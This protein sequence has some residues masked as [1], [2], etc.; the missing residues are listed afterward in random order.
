MSPRM[1]RLLVLLPVLCFACSESSEPGVSPSLD[2]VTPTDGDPVGHGDVSV[3][4]SDVQ[5]EP[6]ADPS[7][8]PPWFGEKCSSNDDCQAEGWADGYCVQ[9]DETGLSQCTQACVS[10]CPPGYGCVAIQ[11]LGGSDALFVCMPIVPTGCDP[12][13]SDLDCPRPGARCLGIGLDGGVDDLRC[14]DPCTEGQAACLAGYVCTSTVVGDQREPAELC[15]PDTG[16]CICF[17]AD[18]S[19]SP[20]NG[21]SRPC[22]S[23]N[24]IGTCTGTELCDGTNGWTG[25]T[26]TQPSAEVCNGTD[27]DCNGLADDGMDPVPCVHQNE[28]GACV[29][30]ETCAGLDGWSCDA[31]HPAAETCDG[32]DEDCNGVV[33]DGFPDMD[34][35]GIAD[36]IDDDVDGDG[37]TDT[38][39]NCPQVSN[40][41]QTDTDSDLLGDACDT[42]DDGDGIPDGTD[43]CPQLANAGQGDLDADAQGDA[44]DAD[45]DGDGVDNDTDVCPTTADPGQEDSDGDGTGDACDDD[46]DGDGVSDAT[47]CAPNDPA[48][49]PGQVEV[50]NGADDDC[51]FITDEGFTDTDADGLADCTDDDD[52][53]DGAVDDDD[54]LPLVATAYPGADEVCNGTDDDCDGDTDEGFPDEDTDGVPDCLDEDLDGDG[55][56]NGADVCPAVADPAQEDLDGDG[57]GDAC[58]ADD[59]GDAIPDGTDNCPAV[60]NTVQTDTDA[61][62]QGDACDDDDDG[63]GVADGADNCALVANAGQADLDSDGVG[64]ACEDDIDG[65][66]APD[67]LDCAPE[68]PAV[69]PGAVEACDGVDNDCSGGVDEGFVDTD[70]DGEKDC[71]DSDDDGDLDPDETDCAPLNA[72]IHHQASEVCNGVDD[73]CDG[74]VDEDLGVLTCGKGNCAHTVPACQDGA[75]QLCDPF[76][77]IDFEVCDGAGNDCDGL[78][79]EDQ[80]WLSCGLGACVHAVYQC[81]DA[82]PVQCDPLEGSS[83]ELCNGLDDDCDGVIDDELGIISCGVGACAKSVPACSDG[84]ANACDADSGKSDEVCDGVD[85]DCDGAVDEGAAACTLFYA[86]ADGDG[87]GGGAGACLCEAQAPYTYSESTDCNDGDAAVKPGILEI[88][89]N[90]K[91]DNCDGLIDAAQTPW[92]DP[93]GPT[94]THQVIVDNSAGP[95]LADY[96]V[97]VDVSALK[98]PNKDL[99]VALHFDEATGAYA[100]GA[101]TEERT[102]PGTFSGA[103]AFTA[104]GLEGAGLTLPGSNSSLQYPLPD[105]DPSG[106][107]TYTTWVYAT[108]YE[109]NHAS[110]AY[111]TDNWMRLFYVTPSAGGAWHSGLE[112][113]TAAGCHGHLQ[114]PGLGASAWKH[115]VLQYEGAATNKAHWYVDGKKILSFSSISF[116][117]L[118][119]AKLSLGGDQNNGASY[120]L[121]GRIDEVLWYKKALSDTEIAAIYCHG[122]AKLGQS[123]AAC[124]GVTDKGRFDHRDIRVLSSDGAGVLPSWIG[125]DR[126]LW[127]KIGAQAAGTTAT[128]PIQYGSAAVQGDDDPAAVFSLYDGFEGSDGALSSD[129]KWTVNGTASRKAH[130]AC[131]DAGAA[132]AADSS[133]GWLATTATFDGA[134]TLEASVRSLSG[135]SSHFYSVLAMPGAPTFY[136]AGSHLRVRDGAGGESGLKVVVDSVVA[137]DGAAAGAGHRIA[138][139]RPVGDEHVTRFDGAVLSSGAW[140]GAGP[141]RL[142]VGAGPGPAGSGTY[143][144]C[145]DR[146]IVRPVVS[147]EP[148]AA[149]AP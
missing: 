73:N 42:D 9:V 81:K 138:L 89:D 112:F 144:A 28:H 109:S 130:R 93:G 105:L 63:D 35:D 65:D 51:D 145:F 136:P 15:I 53:N 80:G 127:F 36:C 47:D 88:C 77:G 117:P 60:K 75:A 115:L 1:L 13:E 8:L 123:P 19:G 59:D 79:D 48:V 129:G 147:P 49:F 108:G 92:C 50:C 118:S 107:F 20:V 62:G 24:E 135:G 126:A 137:S 125:S 46:Q 26:A 6:D 54:C 5:V 41:E 86:D 10:E 33:D 31:P 87:F 134:V 30:T 18:E 16:S 128:Y 43:N 148:K 84:D 71:V 34:V 61:D 58:D 70:K 99:Y 133:A 11:N 66:G 78:T 2:A 69:K 55:V 21:S 14:A 142:L 101:Q 37:I 22:T 45:L 32:V 104:D 29:G 44:C 72:A 96:A 124:A 23:S 149:L 110:F 39:D 106:G 76:E 146:V 17:G 97:R 90:G 82:L 7:E 3:P 64:D 91:D 12:C 52:D 116:A 38:V 120:N 103:A 102:A 98:Y 94:L 57:L 74:G 25:C 141:L 114:A 27:N 100:E 122:A 56:P 68:D 95:A 139:Q 132:P 143:T 83:P 111:V 67:A 40:P 121:Q 4:P 140:S 113:C 85:N 119:G 131:L